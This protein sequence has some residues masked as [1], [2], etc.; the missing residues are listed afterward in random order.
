MALFDFLKSGNTFSKMNENE[1]EREREIAFVSCLVDMSLS[2]GKIDNQESEILSDIGKS[3]NV[4]NDDVKHFFDRAE[5]DKNHIKNVLSSLEY[6][7]KKALI[8]KLW[9]IS[10]LDGDTDETES[11]KIASFNE[12]MGIGMQEFQNIMIEHKENLLNEKAKEKTSN[13]LTEFNVEIQ[14]LYDSIE[15][16][17]E[18]ITEERISYWYDVVNQRVFTYGNLIESLED[19]GEVK[20][21]MDRKIGEIT[22]GHCDEYHNRLDGEGDMYTGQSFETLDKKIE[23]IKIRIIG[24][25]H[26]YRLIK[27]LPEKINEIADKYDLDSKSVREEALNK[28]IHSKSSLFGSIKYALRIG[29]EHE[30]IR[31][32]YEDFEYNKIDVEGINPFDSILDKVESKEID[33]S[34]K[35]S[36]V[37][38]VAPENLSISELEDYFKNTVKDY[39]FSSKELTDDKVVTFDKENMLIENK[40][41]LNIEGVDLSSIGMVEEVTKNAIIPLKEITYIYILKEE[42][43]YELVIETNSDK[44][45][46]NLYKGDDPSNYSSEFKF[47]LSKKLNSDNYLISAL[48]KIILS[49]CKDANSLIP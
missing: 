7:D 36:Q 5:K 30:T 28:Y 15:R 16:Q 29:I 6:K 41:G 22:W 13:E 2:D 39:S 23:F 3:L 19:M 44:I 12:F 4:S 42:K 26:V 24:F 27:N 20:K 37:S 48:H 40:L 9:E 18:S 11:S 32:W 43:K 10:F 47:F 21:S 38:I 46:T 17:M 14:N 33:E 31:T 45:Y 8:I 49:K 35:V 1:R 25:G 34:L